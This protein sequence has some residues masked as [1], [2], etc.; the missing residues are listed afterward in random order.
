MNSWISLH[1]EN[2]QSWTTLYFIRK[3]K[4]LPPNVVQY[5]HRLNMELD[6]LGSMSRD[7]HCCTQWLRP[8]NLPPSP[9][10]WAH[11]HE[12]AIGQ[13]R[14]RHLFVTPWVQSMVSVLFSTL[15][16][17]SDT[18]RQTLEL[19]KYLSD[20]TD[21]HHVWDGEGESFLRR[22]ILRRHL[23]RPAHRFPVETGTSG[24]SLFLDYFRSEEVTS[25]KK[26]HK[27]QLGFIFRPFRFEQ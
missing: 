23:T 10:I 5:N 15:F 4:S 18:W 27:K 8:R 16:S 26:A 7:V 12:G 22:G 21:F 17:I 20:V 6:Y 3:Y 13:R 2:F 24:W 11:I 9:R 25:N 19:H 1:K 14:R